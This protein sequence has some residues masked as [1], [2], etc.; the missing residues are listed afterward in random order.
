[1]PPLRQNTFSIVPNAP[2]D[3]FQFAAAGAAGPAAVPA[4]KPPMT[5]KQARKLYNQQTRAPRRT[6][7]EQRAWEKQEQERIRKELDAERA[8]SRARAA[9]ERKKSKEEAVRNERKK[10][11]LPLGKVR[12][13]QGTI[14]RFLFRGKRSREATEEAEDSA[15]SCVGSG[16][17]KENGCPGSGSKRRRLDAVTGEEDEASGADEA[18]NPHP[19]PAE[20]GVAA[21][22]R[23]PPMPEPVEAPF[24]GFE[25]NTNDNACPTVKSQAASKDIGKLLDAASP[26]SPPTDDS[27]HNKLP[28]ATVIL[29][30][31][32]A[33][34]P[35][36]DESEQKAEPGPEPASGPEPV[37]EPKHAPLDEPAPGA[38]TVA[39]PQPELRLPASL[40]PPSRAQPVPQECNTRGVEAVPLDKKVN[41]GLAILD[42]LPED[43]LDEL[44]LTPEE[45]ET[46]RPTLRTP[47]PP[48]RPSLPADAVRLPTLIS[49]GQDLR[50]KPAPH[51]V[52][53]VR[54][55]GPVNK[56]APSKPTNRGPPGINTPS[57]LPREIARPAQRSMA[58][59]PV[60]K[61]KGPLRP[62]ATNIQKNTHGMTRA[63][64]P[65][66]AKPHPQR[67]V[68]PEPGLPPTSTQLF[69]L[70]NFDDIIPSLSQEEKELRR[71]ESRDPETIAPP[72]P[73][74]RNLFAKPRTFQPPPRLPVE[75]RVVPPRKF[76]PPPSR[77]LQQAKRTPAVSL[78]KDMNLDFLSTQDLMSTQDVHEV[79]TTVPHKRGQATEPGAPNGRLFKR[80]PPFAPGRSSSASR[81]A[82]ENVLSRPSSMRPPEPS[83]RTGARPQGDAT[84]KP[85]IPGLVSSPHTT[86]T[87][88][89]PRDQH[90]DRIF[91]API[92]NNTNLARKDKY[93]ALEA[94]NARPADPA[95]GSL[96]SS[97]TGP[98]QSR[99]HRPSQFRNHVKTTE[100]LFDSHESSFD[101]GRSRASHP[102]GPQ[103][104]THVDKDPFLERD[105][106]ESTTSHIRQQAPGS[107]RAPQPTT[108]NG[109]SANSA[110]QAAMPRLTPRASGGSTDSNAPDSQ[111]RPRYFTSSATRVKINLAKMESIR[112]F[113]VEERMR[114]RQ[115]AREKTATRRTEISGG[116]NNERAD[117]M[118]V[119]SRNPDR[120]GPGDKNGGKSDGVTGDMATPRQ[121]PLRNGGRGPARLMN[122][123]Y[124]HVTR[125]GGQLSSTQETD[126]GD[127]DLGDTFAL[128]ETLNR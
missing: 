42:A 18:P 93:S 110:K 98:A 2:P 88:K 60:P 9:R 14:S 124:G 29:S 100:A 128:F 119:H 120:R 78:T 97:S 16:S 53:V 89:N 63:P 103:G 31:R 12:P 23:P 26:N 21:N 13:S 65:S 66:L 79:E 57:V 121:Q 3:P 36:A 82:A 83:C 86:N 68:A 64:K 90:K 106:H 105:A 74:R 27:S 45:V 15:G 39:K 107:Q 55:T 5:T 47:A 101:R 127:I 40:E 114:Q 43:L 118:Q 122:T 99:P 41:A 46:P 71:N 59:P 92:A 11:G 6:K 111:G 22:E 116:D 33:P 7:V 70:N 30:P 51:T 126:Y 67:A 52:H 48:P 115:R 37:P 38:E 109:P 108:S 102:T 91:H 35:L 113:E 24:E 123:A 76:A 54:R 96:V 87:P 117:G 49:P 58:P 28:E 69:L 61:S 73:Q 50:E 77:N 25:S 95:T 10:Q 72:P 84:T 32:C 34:P 56:P 19:K 125:G 104:T 85:G 81:L 20:P 1:M 8:A 62:L 17:D 4:A 44:I 94:K 75:R 112:T 80:P